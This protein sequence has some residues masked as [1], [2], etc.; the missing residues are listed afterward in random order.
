MY[1]YV[2]V[3]IRNYAKFSDMLFTY[4]ISDS[5]IDKIKVGQ[6]L[7]VRFGNSSKPIEALAVNIHEDLS[8]DMDIS[9]IKDVDVII[10]EKP[11]IS[12]ENINL[13]YWI[14]ERYMCTYGEAL[15]LFYPKGYSFSVKKTVRLSKD[16]DEIIKICDDKKVLSVIEY[17][18]KYN[19]N[20]YKTLT[21]EFSENLIKKMGINKYIAIEWD[22]KN[23]INE[24]KQEIYSLSKPLEE[25]LMMESKTNKKMGDKQKKVIEFLSLNDEI[26]KDTI[27]IVCE[28]NSQ[29]LKSLVKRGYVEYTER[30]VNR[31]PIS[32]FSPKNKEI[33]LNEEQTRVIEEFEKNRTQGE[34]KPILLHG[35]TGSGKT[36]VYL[37]MMEKVLS[38]G[39]ECLLLV[40]EI[41]LTP[42]MISR[43]VSRFGS[44]V[45]AYNSALNDGQR[46]DLFREV[47]DG[48]IKVV[49][50]TR[51]SL[52]M[53]FPNLGLIIVDEEHDSSYISG[54]NPK[55][56]TLDICRF[57]NFKYGVAVVYGSATPSVSDYYK[58]INNEYLLLE[59]KNRANNMSLPEIEIVDMRREFDRGNFFEIS[60][61]LLSEIKSTI[62][63]KKQVI[64]FINRRGYANFL[65]CKKCGYVEKC[66]NCDISLTYHKNEN[67]GRCHYCGYEKDMHD[68]LCP[69]CKLA[70]LN[71][72]GVGTEKIEE[73]IKNIYP[74]Y[75][76][77]RIDKDTTSKKG[78]L[79]SILKKFD[80]GEADILIGT[81]LLAKGHDFEKVTLVGILS[82]DMMLNFPDYRAFE[83][84]Y[85]ILTQVSG[86]A[87]RGK[88][89][90]KVVLQT[91]DVDHYAIKTST[92]YD[93]E[94][95]YK[96]EIDIRK[97]F[98]YE[99]FNNI[100]R[101]IVSGDNEEVVKYN[102]EKCYS[103]IK[104]LMEEMGMYNKRYLLGPSQCSINKIN[105]KYR[106][107]I[108][109][110][111]GTMD[112]K[113]TKAMLKYVCVTKHYE[114]FNEKISVSIE[115][116]PSS[117]L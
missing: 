105:G 95:F 43:V 61:K 48:N 30:K 39:R 31:K 44:L 24:K 51:S 73:Y 37:N 112:L 29:T 111:N 6:I 85:Q 77:L 36:E 13:L 100:F 117:Y 56:N 82:A 109:I 57:L 72:I 19:I 99:P 70:R 34:N 32:E 93:Y 88:Y 26:E 53:P 20:D 1:M 8:N 75:R 102:A 28:V 74:Q 25:I 33:R 23:K 40:P 113:N 64:L 7:G 94:G 76:V 101:V 35:I 50:G 10:D 59:M 97:K 15:S 42:L 14:R 83:T 12:K 108:I 67:I 106:W 90:G 91:Y 21:D 103:T 4:R 86:R 96:R 11:I 54:S 5:I 52:F 62:E 104:Y 79:E 114:I 65:T 89:R 80:E 68:K 38:E 2:D 9:K 47:R 81:Q 41:A 49:V 45:G 115:E 110:K 78:E 87:G 27:M 16:I 22:F 46:H 107:Q 63:E 18:K 66:D 116:N 84:T 17:I 92:N 98:K 58:A 60:E 55:Y 3:I 69:S 71:S